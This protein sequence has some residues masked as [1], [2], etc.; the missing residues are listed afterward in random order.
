MSDTSQHDQPRSE[1]TES[2]GARQPMEVRSVVTSAI[3]VLMF[4]Y[5]L[6]F[7]RNFFIPIVLALSLN[8][9]LG[10]LVNR[11]RRL[12][13]PRPLG[14][15]LVL[16]VIIGGLGAGGYAAVEPA[17]QWLDSMPQTMEDLKS[18]TSVIRE[19]VENV[20]QQTEQI[21]KVAE[22]AVNEKKET[23][24]TTTVVL[25][26]PG[27][28]ERFIGSLQAFA[29]T[30][31]VMLILLYFML[32]T[33][34][35]MIRKL[36]AMIRRQI[37]RRQAVSLVRHMQDDI[38]RYLVTIIMINTALGVTVSL[39]LWAIG[40]PDPFL[41]G[42]VAGLLNFAPYL[43]AA[44][45][46]LIITAISFATF[47]SLA[48]ASIAPLVFMLI[49]A[50]EGNFITPAIHGKRFAMN[51]LAIYMSLFFWGWLWG[52]AGVIVAIPLIAALKIA[53]DHVD[54][55]RPIGRLLGR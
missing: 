6:Y 51:P 50:I 25:K 27:L 38:N 54:S 16:F 46:F 4:L 8:M 49:T 9:L 2:T 15:A 30:L 43:G 11:L 24:R 36:L 18:R 45:A 28:G 55:M 29:G 17:K 14:A 40:L 23:T 37:G 3:L 10:P 34:G 19:K 32:A 48:Y 13:I 26:E 39:T 22:S 47:T 42:A 12:W 33:G 7:A 21:I 1:R 53:C 31:A 52:I 41:W 44:V 5:T 20:T 35:L